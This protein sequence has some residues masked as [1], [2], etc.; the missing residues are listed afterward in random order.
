[1]LFIVHSIL[2]GLTAVTLFLALRSQS[3]IMG[4]AFALGFAVYPPFIYQCATSPESTIV[5]LFFLSVFFYHA[6]A[7]QARPT[8]KRFAYLGAI[9]GVLGMTNPGTLVFTTVSLCFAAFVVCNSYADRI[10]SVMAAGAVILVVITPWFIRNYLLF[11]KV[12]M[13][14]G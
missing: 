3:N 4:L 11:E 1:A 9:A 5:L 13:R 8:L 14:A 7:L 10:K 12:V 2:A 6:A